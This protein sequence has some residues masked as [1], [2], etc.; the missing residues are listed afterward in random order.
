[1]GSMTRSRAIQD[2]AHWVHRVLVVH[3]GSPFL[4]QTVPLGVANFVT[5]P[6]SIDEPAKHLKRVEGPVSV[7]YR[8]DSG[9]VVEVVRAKANVAALLGPFSTTAVA[10]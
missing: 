2:T 4:I 8:L 9:T 3:G 6:E 7:S 1:M 10:V 5:E